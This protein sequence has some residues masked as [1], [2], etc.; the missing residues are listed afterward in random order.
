MP[1]QSQGPHLWI[2]SERRNAAG[3]V[4]HRSTFVIIDRGCQIATGCAPNEPAA[5]EQELARYIARKYPTI[6]APGPRDPTE[7]PL[8]DVLSTYIVNVVDEHARP[9]ESKRRLARIAAFF[10]GFRLGE[11]NGA[12]CRAYAKQS[13]TDPMARRDLEELRAAINHH[14]REGLHDRLISVLLPERRPPRERWLDRHEVARLLWTAWRR[15]KCRQAAKFILV[16]L[17]TGRRAAVVCSATFRKQTGRSFIDIVNG[18][19]SPPEGA[20]KT[21]KRNP[22]IPLPGRLLVHLRAWHRNGQRYVIEWGGHATKRI[23]P[24]IKE[25]AAAAGLGHVTP[26][27]LRHTAATWLM[28]AGVDML[29]AGRYLGMT[30]RTLENTYAHH[31][32]DHLINARDAFSHAGKGIGKKHTIANFSQRNA[33]TKTDNRIRTLKKAQRN[34]DRSLRTIVGSE[35]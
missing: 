18:M 15:P 17:Y 29:E 3:I 9:E 8:A 11:V 33:R 14:R 35:C 32:P 24:T 10:G 19:W 25:I 5:A 12:L 7:I 30:T 27:V 4:T 6:I 1:R 22:P 13:S 23:D 21:K 16:A 34:Q 31:R 26:H 2:R 20:K 28:H